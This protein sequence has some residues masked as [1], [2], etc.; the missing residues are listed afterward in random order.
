MLEISSSN[1]TNLIRLDDE[2]TA[3]K[4]VVKYKMSDEKREIEVKAAVWSLVKNNTIKGGNIVEE[5][6]TFKQKTK[7]SK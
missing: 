2:G 4:A 1:S 7:V 5:N 6:T 3:V